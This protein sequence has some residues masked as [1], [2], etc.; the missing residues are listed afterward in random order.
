MKGRGINHH[1][2]LSTNSMTTNH[3]TDTKLYGSLASHG[4]GN[5]NKKAVIDF[6]PT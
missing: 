3:L 2:M 5:G 4:I 6:L 1:P